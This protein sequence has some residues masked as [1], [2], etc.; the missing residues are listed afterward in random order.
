MKKLVVLVLILITCFIPKVYGEDRLQFD[1]VWLANTGSPQNI[2]LNRSGN[3]LVNLNGKWINEYSPTGTKKYS[4]FDGWPPMYLGHKLTNLSPNAKINSIATSQNQ[5]KIYFSTGGTNNIDDNKVIILDKNNND[6][7][8]IGQYGSGNGEFQ[9]PRGLAISADGKLYVADSNNYRIQV[10]NPDGTYYSQFGSRGAGSGQFNLPL[11][12]VAIKNDGT[13]LVLDGSKVHQFRADGSF[14]TRDA[15]NTYSSASA[16]TVDLNGNVYV[17]DSGKN[18]IVCSMIDGS[19][20]TI[21]GTAGVNNGQF[22][23][24]TDLAVDAFGSLYIVDHNNQRIQ[25]FKKLLF[26]TI[27]V[28]PTAGTPP[29][30]TALPTTTTIPGQGS[31][32]MTSSPAAPAAATPGLYYRIIF[33]ASG[34]KFSASSKFTTWSVLSGVLPAWLRM[35]SRPS[36]D[37]S[38]STCT[39]NGVP[40]ATESGKKYDFT[41]RAVDNDGLVGEI[42]CSFS[43]N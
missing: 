9:N 36:P 19:Q 25:K 21:L 40:R 18:R 23:H 5:S 14:I 26:S 20:L 11:I 32:T 3:L 13:I 31:L 1:S 30:P 41:L 37:G 34:G 42:S 35:S 7:L 4:Y 27:P 22:N 16:I 29:A 24:P 15:E 12:D 10:F 17:V 43:V 8:F 2:T 6:A 28:A 39:L 33:T 38:M